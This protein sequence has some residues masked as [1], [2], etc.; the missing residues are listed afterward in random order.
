MFVWVYLPVGL[1]DPEIVADVGLP[2]AAA[3]CKLLA[4]AVPIPVQV[5]IPVRVL[6]LHRLLIPIPAKPVVLHKHECQVARE[7]LLR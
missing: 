4:T 6:R 5:H 3:K 7:I 1:A 2:H